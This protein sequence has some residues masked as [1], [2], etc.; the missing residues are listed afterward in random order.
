MV[1]LIITAKNGTSEEK[2]FQN[3]AQALA[4]AYQNGACYGAGKI[5]ITSVVK[6]PGKEPERPVIYEPVQPVIGEP[7]AKQGNPKKGKE[8]GSDSTDQII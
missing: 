8:A 2:E 5:E 7:V 3:M 1:K 6:E 4:F